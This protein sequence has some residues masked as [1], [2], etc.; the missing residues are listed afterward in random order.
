M[1][2]GNLDVDIPCPECRKKFKMKL[3]QIR[4]GAKVTCPKCKKVIKL[5]VE[6]DDLTRPDKELNK[7]LDNLKDININIDL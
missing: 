5:K 2:F 7:L 3:H 1:V 6:G 4:N